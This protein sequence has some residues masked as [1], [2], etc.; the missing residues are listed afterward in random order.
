MSGMQVD[1]AA[2]APFVA[3][4]LVRKRS[5]LSFESFEAHQHEV[6]IPLV[7]ALPGL[8]DYRLIFL[9]TDTGRGEEGVNGGEHAAFHA[10]AQVAFESEAAYEAAM[11]SPEGERALADLPNMLDM[12]AVVV[13]TSTTRDVTVAVG[14][15]R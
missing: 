10:V 15:G 1:P 8:L 4:F 11:A 2:G 12:A 5:D 3:A 6:H 14:G 7:L 9:P 13:Q